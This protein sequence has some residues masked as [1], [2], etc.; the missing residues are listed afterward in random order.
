MD[1]EM[2][3]RDEEDSIIAALKKKVGNIEEKLKIAKAELQ[4]YGKEV[5]LRRALVA[6]VGIGA[7]DGNG[8]NA[9]FAW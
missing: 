1:D 3:K 7:K 2:R 8:D 9:K 6:E 4:F 5:E